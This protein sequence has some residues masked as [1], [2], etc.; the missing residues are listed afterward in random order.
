MRE[1]FS[2]TLETIADGPS[3][4]LAVTSPS[5]PGRAETVKIGKSQNLTQKD[6]YKANKS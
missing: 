3:P 4:S 2:W 6:E 5:G 1:H